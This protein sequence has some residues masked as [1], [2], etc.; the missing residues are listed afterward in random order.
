MEDGLSWSN[1]IAGERDRERELE[2]MERELERA[3]EEI[4]RFKI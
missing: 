1:E 3:T 2:T 4:W